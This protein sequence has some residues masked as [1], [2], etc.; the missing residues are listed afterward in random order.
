MDKNTENPSSSQEMSD[1]NKDLPLKEEASPSSAPKP[2]PNTTPKAPNPL[3]LDNSKVE[4]LKE[5][6]PTPD[7]SANIENAYEQPPRK[8]RLLPILLVFIAV[9]AIVFLVTE[10]SLIQLPF[11]TEKQ[12][13][14]K[15]QSDNSKVLKGAASITSASITALHTQAYSAFSNIV[16]T[17][18]EGV[19]EEEAAVTAEESLSNETKQ[20]ASL[21]QE[22]IS[23]QEA[24]KELEANTET[25]P[26]SSSTLSVDP[27][28]TT[29][30][31]TPSPATPPNKNS[32]ESEETPQTDV[33]GTTASDST[34]EETPTPSL[35]DNKEAIHDFLSSAPINSLFIQGERSKMTFN[36]KI[37]RL[38]SLLSE[39]L[40]L[41]WIGIDEQRRVIRLITSEGIEYTKGY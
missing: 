16:S 11:T 32:M 2:E 23:V 20:E 41:K 9:I 14:Q 21:E 33:T 29:T 34:P 19:I 36:G 22:K 6:E 31:Q 8:R 5:K 10:L 7:E 18:K 25:L 27:S 30:P 17:E 39:A 35:N 38:G 24:E 15:Q 3:T 4:N 26:P 40:D 28:P 12:P 13:E 37:Y 1:S